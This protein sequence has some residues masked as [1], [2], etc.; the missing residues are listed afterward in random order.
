M[1]DRG[2]RRIAVRGDDPPELCHVWFHGWSHRPPHPQ[3]CVHDESP[4]AIVEDGQGK[5]HRIAYTSVQFVE[6]TDA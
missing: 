6:P 2:L 3:S 5:I 1:T 4:Y